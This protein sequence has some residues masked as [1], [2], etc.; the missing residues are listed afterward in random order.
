MKSKSKPSISD[1]IVQELKAMKSV[2]MKVPSTAIPFAQENPRVLRE[3]RSNG[4]SNREIA[5]LVIEA[6]C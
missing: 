6:C 3:F 2:G 5:D 1:D 4:A